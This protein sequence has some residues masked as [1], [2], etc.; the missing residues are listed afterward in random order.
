MFKKQPILYSPWLL[1]IGQWSHFLRNL[2][3]KNI[4]K[5]LLQNNS[6]KYNMFDLQEIKVNKYIEEKEA[7]VI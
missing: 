4:G 1:N 2:L 3:T 5:I 6:F 7:N